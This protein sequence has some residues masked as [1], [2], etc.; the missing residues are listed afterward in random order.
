MREAGA[1]LENEDYEVF[2]D[3]NF[4]FDRSVAKLLLDVSERS[5]ICPDLL[6]YYRGITV[7]CEIDA[8]GDFLQVFM[9][10][11]YSNSGR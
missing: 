4:F 10:Q 6:Q 1:I 7:D 3:S 11:F 9:V 8:Y 2:V 5:R